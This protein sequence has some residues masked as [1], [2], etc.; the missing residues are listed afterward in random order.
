MQS[1]LFP[2]DELDFDDDLEIIESSWS[3]KFNL[4]MRSKQDLILESNVIE[5]LVIDESNRM[6]RFVGGENLW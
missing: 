2:S 1:K 4:L 6:G 5:F 3:F